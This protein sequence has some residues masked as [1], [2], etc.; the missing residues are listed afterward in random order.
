M[1]LSDHASDV[2]SQFGED[3]IIRTA[4]DLVGIKTGRVVEFGAGDGLELSNTAQF[5]K[6]SGWPALLIEPD[7]FRFDG[8]QK[9]TAGYTNV[10]CLPATVQP[11][12]HTDTIDSICSRWNPDDEPIVFMSVDVDDCE[13]QILSNMNVRPT[14]LLV[15]FN[16]T[17][18]HHLELV[19]AVGSRLQAS[20][21]AIVKLA[22]SMGYS[23]ISI[24]GCNCLFVLKEHFDLFEAYDTDYWNLVDRKAST[25]VV[26]D[27]LGNYIYIGPKP[28]GV[29]APYE[30]PRWEQGPWEQQS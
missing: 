15:E 19:G 11:S 21:L 16:Y 6:D 9:N 2:Y 1:K 8:L 24:S 22:E 4:M 17:M 23:L 25:F 28:H 20:P 5:W 30:N 14:L 10:T 13:Y 29:I 7:Q 18:P 12:G 27:W 3:G 26:T